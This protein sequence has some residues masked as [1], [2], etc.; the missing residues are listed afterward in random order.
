ML[1]MNYQKENRRVAFI[2][3]KAKKTVIETFCNLCPHLSSP[4]SSTA[5]KYFEEKCPCDI[6]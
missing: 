4:F 2:Y 6:V 5:K 1:S 3:F